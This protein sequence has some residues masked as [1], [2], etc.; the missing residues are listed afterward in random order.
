MSETGKL[1]VEVVEFRPM[2][3]NT[4]KGF[5]TV[6]I[7]AMRLTIRDCSVHESNGKRWIGL[8]A[9]AQI[10]RD[11]ELVR[12]DGKVQYAAVFEFDSRAVGDAFSAA[13]L[14]ALDAREG[15]AAA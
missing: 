14:R 2:D 7:P 9:K 15:R 11:Q 5:V 6:R 12:R 8:P 4:L 1:A 10:G 3:R 13:V